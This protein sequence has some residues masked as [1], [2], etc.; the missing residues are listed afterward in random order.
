MKTFLEI[1]LTALVFA[2][3]VVYCFNAAVGFVLIIIA[4]AVTALGVWLLPKL[5]K[6]EN[7]TDQSQYGV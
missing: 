7:D 3:I 2:S 1:I 6:Q 4:L 5:K